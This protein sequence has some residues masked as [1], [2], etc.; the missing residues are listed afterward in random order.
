L[1]RQVHLHPILSH[2]ITEAHCGAR[3]WSRTLVGALLGL[4][5]S[6]AACWFSTLNQKVVVVVSSA[7][8]G[9]ICGYAL[10][11]CS[12]SVQPPHPVDPPPVTPAVE[13]VEQPLVQRPVPKLRPEVDP[14]I[15]RRMVIQM[16]NVFDIASWN[17]QLREGDHDNLEY[18]AML[19]RLG[20]IQQG[21]ATAG[22]EDQVLQLLATLNLDD[23]RLRAFREL[24]FRD[25]EPT[26]YHWHTTGMHPTNERLVAELM[27]I[28]AARGSAARVSDDGIARA[29]AARNAVTL[30]DTLA[31]PS[32]GSIYTMALLNDAHF[33]SWRAAMRPATPLRETPLPIQPIWEDATNYEILAPLLNPWMQHWRSQPRQ[34]DQNNDVYR[35]LINQF[36]IP[37][38]TPGWLPTTCRLIRQLLPGDQDHALALVQEIFCLGVQPRVYPSEV[39]EIGTKWRCHLAPLRGNPEILVLFSEMVSPGLNAVNPRLNPSLGNLENLIA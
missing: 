23:V 18:R 11:C 4:G 33:S 5:I 30:L 15:R 8:G 31:N 6:L 36:R 19:N 17:G 13:V 39:L 21:W 7:V 3:D 24:L 9:G 14:L 28:G 12:R 2:P 1:S 27:D 32:T 16:C 22:D 35:E 34:T 29:N 38:R 10:G 25:V 20:P 26:H 37:G